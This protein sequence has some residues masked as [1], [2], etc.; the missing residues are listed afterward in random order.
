[1][2]LLG[3][4]FRQSAGLLAFTVFAGSVAGV[5]AAGLISVIARSISAKNGLVLIWP[6]V[7]LCLLT[8][9]AGSLAGIASIRL[10]QGA[11][12]RMRVDLSRKILATRHATLQKIGRRE[13]YTILNNDILM[14]TQSFQQMPFLLGQLV[15]LL[16]CLVYMAWLSLSLFLPFVVLLGSTLAFYFALERI[17]F[18]K[19]VAM[20]VQ[21]D[22]LNAALRDLIDGSRELQL[23]NDRANYFLSEVL[24]RQ[25]ALQRK[26]A[27]DSLSLFALVSTFG[28]ILF[29][30][31]MG[32]VLFAAPFWG[33]HPGAELTQFAFALLYI[34]GPI[35]VLTTSIQSLRNGEIA[36][37]RIELL[38]K[39]LP[40]SGADD[41]RS[42]TRDPWTRAPSSLSLQSVLYRYRDELDELSYTLGPID[43]ELRSGEITFIVGGN[44]S[45]KTTL[46]MLLLG[47]YEP[48]GG[49]ILLDG[50][51]VDS[52]NRDRYRQHFSA[53]F[54]DFH[55]FEQLLQKDREAMDHRANAYIA[56]FGLQSKVTAD[57]GRF[58]TIK[59]SSGQRKRLALVASFMEDRP[60]YLF[61][62]WAADQDPEF[63]RVF[64]RELLPD[65]RARGKMVIVISHDDAYFDC[66]DRVLRLGDGRLL[67][68]E[69]DAARRAAAV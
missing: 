33:Q 17:P 43:V 10:I 31:I 45:G 1:M 32:V 63:K 65:L 66:A 3:Y 19:L 20:R 30:L 25:A 50:V 5:A 52:D 12:Y 57:G 27:N 49:T 8:V 6:F 15:L 68:V 11:M 36:L 54:A 53:V 16:A 48:M 41:A 18:R 9:I 24:S 51:I 14:V 29:Y 58:S 62:E 44:G 46:G 40:E 56:R 47:L 37:R 61:D 67:D 7:G 60:I 21:L 23:N 42:D 64:Y 4:V 2:R 35:Q 39:T 22:D 55:L 38:D 69:V 26:L 59:L 34:L 28:N 13:L